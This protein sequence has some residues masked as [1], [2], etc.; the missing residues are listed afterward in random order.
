MSNRV[1]GRR[2]ARQLTVEELDRISGATGT[3]T[4]HTTFTGPIR[5]IP[6][7]DTHFDTD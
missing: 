1:V 6:R 4:A 2:G 3:I 7:D 5:M